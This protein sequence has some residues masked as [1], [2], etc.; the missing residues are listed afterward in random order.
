MAALEARV[1]E[2]TQRLDTANAPAA[3]PS[4]DAADNAADNDN[5]KVSPHLL[6]SVVK[7]F[8]NVGTPNHLMPWQTRMQSIASG[9]GFIV[10]RARRLIMTNTHVIRH[11]RFIEIRGYGAGRRFTAVPVFIAADCDLALLHVA[12]AAFWNDELEEA[13]FDM[14]PP[15][16]ESAPDAAEANTGLNALVRVGPCD[17]IPKLQASVKVVGFPMGGDQLS[18]TSGVVSR[19]DMSPYGGIGHRLATIQIDAAI[20][21]GNSGGPAVSGG[22]KVVGIAFQTLVAGD[23]IGYLIP[24]SLVAVCVRAFLAEAAAIL[25]SG[26]ASRGCVFHPGFPTVGITFQGMTNNA[27][28]QRYGLD[29]EGAMTGIL[30][31]SVQ[32]GSTAERKLEVGDVLVSVNGKDIANDSTI[33]WRHKERICFSHLVRAA[34]PGT[35]VALGV[36]RNRQLTTVQLT[37]AISAPLLPAHLDS[38]A[39]RQQPPYAIFGGC[40][41]TLASL[42]FLLEW[43]QDQWYHNAPRHLTEMLTHG[44]RSEKRREVVIMSMILPHEA[45]KG[46]TSDI[47]VN[48][49]VDAVNGVSVKDFTQFSELLAELKDDDVATLET[50]LGDQPPR[51]PAT[52]VFRV[53]EAR[54]AD[55]ELQQAYGLPALFHNPA[56]SAPDGAVADVVADATVA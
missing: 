18:I 5:A 15:V 23:G 6:R 35:D 48:R 55:K 25:T 52:L 9:S 50:T 12:D 17:A 42:P 14:L 32:Y 49:I 28:R 56:T 3:A 29:E 47:F 45:N 46:Y 51:R 21:P 8:A 41:F 39:Y 36:W 31:E 30:V 1:A 10:D 13:Q 40:V 38:A 22:S 54:A 43:G 19:I 16:D 44:D 11:A 4:A 24:T 27:L 53:G 2:L 37:R 34:A 20:N 33:E 26:G 7:I